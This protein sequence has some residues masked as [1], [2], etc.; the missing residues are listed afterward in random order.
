MCLCG[1]VSIVS[2]CCLGGLLAP[3]ALLRCVVTA[4]GGV[5]V[6]LVARIADWMLE[7]AHMHTHSQAN[8]MFTLALVLLHHVRML[9][10]PVCCG[11]LVGGKVVKRGLLSAAP[12]RVMLLHESLL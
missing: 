10:C 2:P 8:D 11:R 4:P 5:V 7:Q 6:V 1:V 3:L 12:W 9:L